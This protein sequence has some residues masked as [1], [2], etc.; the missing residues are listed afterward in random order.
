MRLRAIEA[1]DVQRALHVPRRPHGENLVSDRR[2]VITY[3][4]PLH[5][6]L[7]LTKALLVEV[8][9]HW[10]RARMSKRMVPLD[11]DLRPGCFPYPEPFDQGAVPSCVLE[12][13]SI[14]LYCSVAAT[15][16]AALSCS[17]F[18][19]RRQVPRASPRGLTLTEGIEILRREYGEVKAR[20]RSLPNDA[21]AVKSELLRGRVVVIGYQ[22]DG[23]IERFHEQQ[24]SSRREHPVLPALRGKSVSAHAV[25]LLGY[26]DQHA[27]FLARNSWG[28]TWGQKGNFYI[29]YQAVET[30]SFVTDLV[31]VVSVGRESV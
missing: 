10:A 30:P 5:I 31:V 4:I 16:R 25:A 1:I 26:S 20:L 8:P 6:Y 14:A 11:V 24:R 18:P 28:T 17:A 15:R 7:F 13:L 29:P 19:A 2:V 27:V 22:V 23:A 9:L 21:S 3:W 12:S